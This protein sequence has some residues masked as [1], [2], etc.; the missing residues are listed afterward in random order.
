MPSSAKQKKIDDLMEKASAALMRT[1]YFEAERMALKALQMSRQIE[2]WDR[3][4]RIALPLQEARRQRVQL[5]IDAA[6]AGPGVTVLD[7]SVTENMSIE[8]GCYLVQPP[9]VGADAR[10]FRLA[11][12]QREVP[13]AVI[14]REPLTQLKLQPIV[15]IGA[16]ST[17]RTKVKPPKSVE[18]PSLAWFLDVME[19]IGDWAMEM[20]DT[21]QELTKQIDT[22]LERLDVVPDH[23]K[24]HQ[25]L[26][27]LCRA[28]LA[29]ESENER[30]SGPSGNSGSRSKVKST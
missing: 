16:G 21:G 17:V 18:A 29:E 13:V 2:D 20:I 8:A 12:L 4:S 19:A 27:E 15:A 7:Q 9:L 10:R 5:A 24:L 28:K 11:A 6:E 23:E 22:L 26:A 14:C 25:K 3:M 30:N 1:A